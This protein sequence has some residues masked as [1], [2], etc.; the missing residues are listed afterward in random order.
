MGLDIGGDLRMERAAGVVNQAEE[1]G[2]G[3]GREQGVCVC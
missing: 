2:D 1:E 3:E